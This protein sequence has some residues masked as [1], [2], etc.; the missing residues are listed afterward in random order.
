[1]LGSE[2]E[3]R[4]V[5]GGDAFAFEVFLSPFDELDAVHAWHLVVDDD[6]GHLILAPFFVKVADG[7][8]D[9]GPAVE[10]AGFALE[11]EFIK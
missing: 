11:L 9:R 10:E 7:L 2:Y 1:M 3:L 6:K 4:Y 8:H 5:L